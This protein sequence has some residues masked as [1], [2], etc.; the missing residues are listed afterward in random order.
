MQDGS[1]PLLR[2]VGVLVEA[3][4]THASAVRAAIALE[5]GATISE[6]YELLEL[7]S[8]PARFDAALLAAQITRTRELVL[9]GRRT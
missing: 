1:D 6:A 7:A 3:G 8:D 4:A 9:V 2:M 5:D